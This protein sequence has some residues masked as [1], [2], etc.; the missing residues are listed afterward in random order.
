MIPVL[1]LVGRPNV[2]KSTLFNRLTRSRDAL[3]A[4]FAGLTRDRQYGEAHHNGR[5]FI[6]IDTGGIDGSE[7]G[8]DAPMADQALLAIEEADLTVLLVDGRAGLNPGDQHIV[9]FLRKQQRPFIV[10]VNKTDG[11]DQDVAMGDFYQLGVNDIHAIAATQGRG[12]SVMLDKLLADFPE[13]ESSEQ[14]DEEAGIKIAVAGRPNVG[15]STLVNRLLGEERVVVYD[16][17]GTTRDSV[18]I[19]YERRG[20]KYTLIDTAGIRRRGKT[21]EVVEKF[22]VVKSLQAIQ[23]ANVVILLVDARDSIVEQDLHL[24]GYVLETG[25][26]LVIALNK[27]DGMNE[28]DKDNVKKDIRRRFVFVD[29][30]KIHFISAL[31]GTGVGNL[32]KS[33]DAAYASASRKLLTPKLNEMLQ[34]IVA[35]HAP[36]MHNNRRIKLRYAHAGGRNPPLIVIHGKQTEKLPASYV[37]YLE[38]TFRKYLKLEG[39]PIRIE[40]RRDDN[41]YTKDE[42]DLSNQQIARKRRLKKNREFLKAK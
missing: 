22:S 31:H 26:A 28:Y 39:T 32:Y 25:R 16:Q 27:W 8:I 33:I 3:V 13:A 36:P 10:A 41:P 19:P 2:G 30:A 1:A 7:E 5:P 38:K 23:D 24:L 15:K 11:I 14:D 20:Q 37:K 40:L 34:R 42:A 6:V 9:D 4:D 29:F 17:P 18:Y 12:V 35:E 21:K